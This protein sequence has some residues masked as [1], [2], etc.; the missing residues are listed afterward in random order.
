[1]QLIA[2]TTAD[3]RRAEN[4]IKVP[5]LGQNYLQIQCIWIWLYFLQELSSFSIFNKNKK[6]TLH[7]A[8]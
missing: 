7:N 2:N 4:S 1:M 3:S 8:L 6:K 5:I